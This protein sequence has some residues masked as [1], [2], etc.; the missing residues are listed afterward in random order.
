MKEMP[1]LTS[2][3][4]PFKQICRA[5]ELM[6]IAFQGLFFFLLCLSVE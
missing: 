5:K 3:V 6:L 4:V 2:V 1:V